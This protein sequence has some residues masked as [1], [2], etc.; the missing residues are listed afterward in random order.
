MIPFKVVI[1]ARYNSSRLPGKPL[2]D[3]GGKTMIARVCEQALKAGA[4]EIVVATDDERIYTEVKKQA[5]AVM[6]TQKNHQ[7]GTERIA[8]VATVLNWDDDA[9][10]VNLQGDEPLISP[11]YIR[12]VAETLARQTRANTATLAANITDSEAIF[13]SNTVKVVTD[14][15]GYAL[16]FSRAPIPWDRDQF[17]TLK[18]PVSFKPYL[19]HIGLYSY[20]VDFLKR[21]CQWETPLLERIEALEQL[22]IL[23][24]GEAIVVKIVEKTPEA[25]IDTLDDLIRV[26]QSFLS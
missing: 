14:K 12:A 13:N 7:S 19:R 26:Q 10:I 18:P 11:D 17:K 21:Y 5:I 24:Y 25:G 9:I 3:I 8:E 2:L 15:H 23:W 1:P 20:R 6:M 22:R 16:Y 4:E